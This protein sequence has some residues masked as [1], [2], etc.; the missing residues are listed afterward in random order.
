MATQKAYEPLES[1]TFQA[2][3]CGEFP[4]DN[5]ELHRG[6]VSYDAADE[7]ADLAREPIE[8]VDELLFDDAVDEVAVGGDLEEDLPPPEQAPAEAPDAFRAF[9]QVLAEV[10]QAFGA[11]AEGTTRLRAL[12]GQ[13]R[14]AG[15]AADARAHAWQGILR[16]ECDDFGLCGAETLDEW[17]AGIVSCVLPTTG[18]TDAIR[19]ELRSHGVAAFGFMAVAA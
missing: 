4:N 3:Q 10:A 12:L 8:V 14:M 1:G 17:A 2:A 7:D 18:R 13:V 9:V 16:G 6:M 19:R 5:P 11:E 15:V